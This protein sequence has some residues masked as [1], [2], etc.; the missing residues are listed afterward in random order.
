MP[1]YLNFNKQLREILKS[2][3]ISAVSDCVTTPFLISV[4]GDYVTMSF[5]MSALSVFKG[6]PFPPSSPSY[7]RQAEGIL[8]I[9]GSD[10]NLLATRNLSKNKKRVCLTTFRG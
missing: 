7:I 1:L 4:V 9:L 6:Y 2:F 3:K 8:E 5:L 10:T